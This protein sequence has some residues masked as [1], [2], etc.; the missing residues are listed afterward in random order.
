MKLTHDVYAHELLKRFNGRITGEAYSGQIT[1]LDKQ[2]I[3]IGMLGAQRIKQKFNS[4]DYIVDLEKQYDNL[5]SISL[6]YLTSKDDNGSFNLY[7]NGDFYYRVAPS[8]ELQR[9]E[10]ISVF[11]AKNSTSFTTLQEINDYRIKNNLPYEKQPIMDVFEKLHFDNANNPIV[12]S[13]GIFK[14]GCYLEIESEFSE[15]ISNMVSPIKDKSVMFNKGNK[16]Y[17]F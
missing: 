7:F 2:D 12:I 16:Q 4:D 13:K 11:N 6:T 14:H 8:F 1:A 9:N 17:E 3:M 15:I 5:P 10:Y